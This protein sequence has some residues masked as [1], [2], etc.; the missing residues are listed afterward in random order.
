MKDF[1]LIANRTLKLYTLLVLILSAQDLI[2]QES[3]YVQITPEKTIKQVGEEFDFFIQVETNEIPL[4]AAQL[5]LT[6]DPDFI[7]V[8]SIELSQDSP[9]EN[10]LPGKKIDNTSGT[11]L[12][13]SFS[14]SPVNA[15]FEYAI[16][17]A[18]AK[19]KGNSVLE[20]A[21]GDRTGTQLSYKG[22]TI[23]IICEGAFIAVK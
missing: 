21:S 13:G 8:I 22:K 6:F 3:I 19:S 4:S 23:D 14:I 10:L 12:I 18:F 11:I 9:L 16:I 17:R 2:G 5:S 20:F 7:E 1:M 15:G